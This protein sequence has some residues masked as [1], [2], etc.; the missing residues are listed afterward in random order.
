MRV[1]MNWS[2]EMELRKP[3]LA[4]CGAAVRK[5]TS[6]ECEPSTPGWETPLR[7]VKSLRSS[8]SSSR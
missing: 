4:G 5:E 2:R 8:A 6:E 7:T 3:P 1:A